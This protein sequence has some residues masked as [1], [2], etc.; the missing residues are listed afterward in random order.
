MP[1]A[2]G[3]ATHSGWA[4]AV[5]VTFDGAR[6]DVVDRRRVE[7]ID[8]DTP[9]QAFHAAAGLPHDDAAALVAR[10]EAAIEGASE[11][12]LD[13]IVESVDDV[14]S[15]GIVGAPRDIP[16]VATVLAS[17]ARMHAS[18]GEQYRRAL[19]EV[20]AAR[21]LPAWRGAS[22][23]LPA[24]SAAAT[25]WT[26]SRLTTALAEIGRALGPPWRK[27]HKEAVLAALASLS[28]DD[29]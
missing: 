24:A 19:A 9:R 17:H 25:G 11:A 13:E 20:A 10:V 1:A 5:T 12:A 26:A 8:E 6:L 15:V 3:F 27:D 29:A 22:D 28:G 21:G 16:D 2:V 18:E 4:I 7:L 23:V 14:E